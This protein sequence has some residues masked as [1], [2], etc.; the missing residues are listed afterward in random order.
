MSAAQLTMSALILAFGV[1]QLFWGPVADRFGRRPVLLA[2]LALYTPASIGS[3]L[4][5]SIGVL[6]VWRALQGAAMAAAVVCARAI[7]RDLYEPHEGAQVMS[8]A[9]SGLGV[10][11]IAGPRA[12]RRDRRRLG[13]ARGAGRGGGLRRVDAGLRGLAA[14]G[15]AAAQEPARP[16]APAPLLAQWGRIARHPTFVAWT[17]LVSS[18]YGGLFTILAGSSFVYID[19]LGLAPGATAWRWPA[20]RLSYLAGTFVCRRWIAAPRHAAAR[21][22]R[23]GGFTLAGG[24]LIVALALAGVHVG[25]GRAAAAVPVRLRP[26]HPPALRPGRRGGT[27]PA[28]RRRGLGAGRLRAGADGLRRRPAGWAARSTARVLPY[29]LGVGFWSLATDAGGLDAGAAPRR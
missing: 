26:R 18:T 7:V 3:L 23:G 21:C 17:L 1:A 5:G 19:V 9:L 10:I 28:R 6:V 25:L 29:A 24:V 2:G 14:A 12:R 11:A 8:L 4:A 16:P 15:D 27:V 13:L 20:A 22:A